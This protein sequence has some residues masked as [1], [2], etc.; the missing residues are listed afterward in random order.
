MAFGRFCF[1]FIKIPFH[2]WPVLVNGDNFAHLSKKWRVAFHFLMGRGGGWGVVVDNGKF[3]SGRIE[4]GTWFM[5]FS[6]PKSPMLMCMLIRTNEQSYW[7]PNTKFRLKNLISSFG[8]VVVQ[9]IFSA[10]ALPSHWRGMLIYL[11][12]VVYTKEN[13]NRQS[14]PFSQVPESPKEVVM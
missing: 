4:V 5:V 3:Y 1:S 11:N 10:M 6:H 13:S 9:A 8:A 12:C 7:V 14:S 2:H